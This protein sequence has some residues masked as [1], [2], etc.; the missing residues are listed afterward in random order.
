MEDT[1]GFVGT[2]PGEMFEKV[3][4]L[5]SGLSAGINYS[6]GILYFYAKRGGQFRSTPPEALGMTGARIVGYSLIRRFYSPIYEPTRQQEEMEDLRSTIYWN[7]V[8]KTDSTGFGQVSF[9]HS[10]EIGHMQVVV[11]GVT[12]DGTLCRGLTSY[13]VTH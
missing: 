12:S 6:G 5:K 4:Y 10:R 9:Y 3:E 7:P 8:V 1:N 2:L 11:E 13:S